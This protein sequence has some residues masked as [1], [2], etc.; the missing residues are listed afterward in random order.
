LKRT[1]GA[2][3]VAML[4]LGSAAAILVAK[5]A[6]AFLEVRPSDAHDERIVEIPRGAGPGAVSRILADAGVITD[7]DS[8]RWFL[9]YRKAAPKLRAGEYR[10]H[11]DLN[12]EEVLDVLANAPEVTRPITF[13]EGLRIEDMAKIVGKSGFGTEEEYLSLV[14]DST[15]I[16]AAGLPLDPPPKSLE[17]FLLPD[18]FEFSRDVNTKAIVDA[19][20]RAFRDLWDDRH[21]ARARELGLSA[22]EVVTLASVVEKETGVPDERPHIAGVFHLRLKKRMKLQSDPTIIYGLTDYHGDI[23]YK[24][25][26]KP[27]PWNTYVID[28]IPPSPIAAPGRA[29]I[30]AVLWPKDTKD[31]FFVSRNDGTHHFSETYREHARMVRKYQ[32]RR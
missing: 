30:D 23:R 20:I 2:I 32:S 12:A 19:Q 31:L 3:L 14:R 10:F 6:T 24:D 21:V 16:A 25:I 18:T 27:H 4:L 1:L 28:G 29:A 9:R 26:L 13:P 8:F 22:N 15:Y 11:T 7:A 17:G 5:R